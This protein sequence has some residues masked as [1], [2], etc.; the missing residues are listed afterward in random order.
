MIYIASPY[1][2][3]NPF[4]VQQRVTAVREYA[5]KLIMRGECAFSP[6]VYAHE[7]ALAHGMGTDA[8][9]WAVFNDKMVQAAK[10]MHVLMLEGYGESL[11]V[12]HEIRYAEYLSLPTTFVFPCA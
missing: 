10:A 4:V 1:S 7:M 9:T 11:G 2:H 3:P 8:K 5:A 6:I 12:Q